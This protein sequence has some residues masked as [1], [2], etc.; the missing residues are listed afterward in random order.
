MRKSRH[1]TH[2]SKA[3][4]GIMSLGSPKHVSEVYLNCLSCGGPLP[5][6]SCARKRLASGFPRTA[7]ERD[8]S[9]LAFAPEVA[10]AARRV[11]EEGFQE[12]GKR[13][14]YYPPWDEEEY[15]ARESLRSEPV[16][17]VHNIS[18]ASLLHPRPLPGSN[19]EEP[20]FTASLYAGDAPHANSRSV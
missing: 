5:C 1:R 14:R 15:A 11:R 18:L 17:A 12:E 7:D 2:Q 3:E 8:D 19:G 6:E 10:E 13:G 16:L 20:D 9:A 4:R